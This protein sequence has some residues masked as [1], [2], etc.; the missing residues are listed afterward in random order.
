MV[1]RKVLKVEW[2]QLQWFRVVKVLIILLKGIILEGYCGVSILYSYAYF[3]VSCNQISTATQLS[4][5]NIM[6]QIWNSSAD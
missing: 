5:I 1:W 6:L 4:G 2:N 3:T